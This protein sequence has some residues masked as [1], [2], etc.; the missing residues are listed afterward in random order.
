MAR[1]CGLL[2]TALAGYTTT[3]AAK[4]SQV[5]CW[6]EDEDGNVVEANV[7]GYSNDVYHARYRV[8]Q[9]F[10][11]FNCILLVFL[12]LFILALAFWHHKRGRYVIWTTPTTSVGWFDG[13]T[14]HGTGRR[15]PA[16]VTERKSRKGK[17]D[18]Y[19]KWDDEKQ[20]G[21]GRK[22]HFNFDKSEET[23]KDKFKGKISSLK[24]RNKLLDEEKE[25]LIKRPPPAATRHNS[26][27]S[28]LKPR[29]NL[30][31]V[32]AGQ[33][34][35]KPI[36]A[37]IAAKMAEERQKVETSRDGPD[38]K[39]S[40]REAAD[41]ARQQARRDRGGATDDER[42]SR[43]AVHQN[44]SAGVK[45]SASNPNGKANA[46]DNERR[47][48]VARRDGS[49]QPTARAPRRETSQTRAPGVQ[50]SGSGAGNNTGR[51]EP[52]RTRQQSSNEDGDRYQ[53][54]NPYRPSGRRL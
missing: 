41:K 25:D 44:S 35:A 12:F 38:R 11:F 23:V 9:A 33:G 52:S 5:E 47:P 17:E 21:S 6:D 51:R 30:V 4:D 22:R 43:P 19:E 32:P 48:A 29:Q 45:R 53:S 50:R 13:P 26:S 34:R 27:S 49:A 37:P 10:A 46:S 54:K 18:R 15:L 3:P 24:D 1:N 14:G 20:V 2:W 40:Q 39:P 36:L 8:L 28:Q 31:S 16:P 7:D 42:P